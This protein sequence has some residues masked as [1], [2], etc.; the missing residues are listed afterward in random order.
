MT[1]DRNSTLASDDSEDSPLLWD[2]SK[3]EEN[4]TFIEKTTKDETK[5]GCGTCGTML[6]EGYVQCEVYALERGADGGCSYC[7][8]LHEAIETLLSSEWPSHE[9]ALIKRGAL[10][11][12]KVYSSKHPVVSIYISYQTEKDSFEREIEISTNSEEQAEHP[13]FPARGL[14]AEDSGSEHCLNMVRK[15]LNDCIRDGSNHEKCRQSIS[16]TLP[17]RVIEVLS[18][19]G[20]DTLR[21]VET[22]GTQGYYNALSHCWGQS[23]SFLPLAT[24]KSN[25]SEHK[26]SLKW[27]SLSKTFQ[28]AI[29]IT[30]HLRIRYLWIDSLCIIQEDE[31]DWMDQA[32]Q[33]GTIYCGAMLTIVATRA[34][35]GGIG[36]FSLRKTVKLE[37]GEM[38]WT[39]SA[40]RFVGGGG[41]YKSI[42]YHQGYW[43][44]QRAKCYGSAEGALFA[45][46]KD[47]FV[48]LP[49]W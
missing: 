41:V 40:I 44:I 31:D 1:A 26:S 20:A 14:I 28:D 8:V 32:P 18:P 6:N 25:I 21:L 48:D 15:W 37:L 35:H 19:T 24:T 46:L 22:E 43:N 7:K 45:S 33:M 10:C 30:R 27:A 13:L 49:L 16:Q 11:S 2:D 9:W 42:F 12:R 34:A 17:K 5:F 38:S 3:R 36:C 23:K 4:D 47:V 39:L 29:K